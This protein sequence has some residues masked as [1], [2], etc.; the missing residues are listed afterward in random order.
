MNVFTDLLK[1]DH[2]WDLNAECQAVFEELKFVVSSETV[3]KLA[4]FG[5]PFEMHTDASD[6]AI[7]GVLVQ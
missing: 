2:I 7:G 6:H 3:L 4:D 1:K 5:A